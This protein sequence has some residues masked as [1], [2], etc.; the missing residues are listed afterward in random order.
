L[1]ENEPG[2]V[3]S[4][5]DDD[6]ASIRRLFQ[7][8]SWLFSGNA[9]ASILGFAQAIVLGRALGVDGYG[10]LAFV[11]AFVTIVNG[12]VDIR[13]WETVTKF[14]GEYHARQDHGR[15]RAMVKLAYLVDLVTGIV[16]FALVAALAR[17][18]AARFAHDPGSA[19]Y[20]VLYAGTLLV[21]TVN[22][23][24]LAILRVFD[25]FRWISSERVAS[26][27][28]RLALLWAAAALTGRLGPVLAAYVAVELAR[29]IVLLVL[30]LRA[31]QNELWRPGPDHIGTV[32][33]RFAEFR[34][35]TLQGAATNILALITRQLDI[36]ILAAIHVPREV[37]LY[38]MAKNF[39]QLV[40]R[41][42]D[43]VY[44][45]IFPQLVRLA[46]RPGAWPGRIRTFVARTTL[47]VLLLILPVG[48]IA[49]FGARF[50]LERAVGSDFV[51]AALPLQIV[52][53]GA[54][55]HAAFLWARPLALAI[56]RPQIPTVAHAAG[57]A[58]LV[59][60]SVVLVPPLGALGSAIT[61]ALVGAVTV[62]ILTIAAL[63][64]RPAGRPPETGPGDWPVAGREERV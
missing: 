11:I 48:A 13:M 49:I 18:A 33:E 52:V 26:A 19:P 24:S 41:I 46:A 47:I 56:G 60:G 20:L 45:A 16:A 57:A 39:G 27:A 4:L 14:V 58:T 36:L 44:H 59:A 17:P 23:T 54:L 10:L 29:A 15:A 2:G 34:S 64:A 53:G 30:G 8:A 7:N 42:S 40:L 6:E 21:A 3:N 38:R 61:F 55:L 37:A 43:P 50:I 63:R 12:V 22:D 51:A 35:F 32:K 25:R 1:R 5:R 28:L 62:G 9:I 31:A